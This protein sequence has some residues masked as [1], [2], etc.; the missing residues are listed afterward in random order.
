[1]KQ[2]ESL[3]QQ[4]RLNGMKDRWKALLETRQAHERV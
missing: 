2:I 1:M 4:L 3:M